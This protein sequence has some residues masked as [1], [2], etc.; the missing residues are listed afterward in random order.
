MTIQEQFG[1]KQPTP[2]M[3]LRAIVA[4]VDGHTDNWRSGI[5]S[6]RAYAHRASSL[7]DQLTA[8]LPF[9]ERG[10]WKE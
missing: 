2:L 8:L 4:A 3:Q 6:H 5:L 9:V 10:D 1:W 7:S